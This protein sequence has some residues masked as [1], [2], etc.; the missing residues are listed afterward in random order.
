MFG[1]ISKFKYKIHTPAVT[2]VEECTKEDTGVGAA[3]ASGSHEQYG[4]IALLVMALS[5]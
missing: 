5:R 1:R 4:H 2:N 3:I